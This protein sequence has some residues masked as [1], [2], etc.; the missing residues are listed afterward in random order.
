MGR[1]Y[2]SLGEVSEIQIL[3][4]HV[5]KT[6]NNFLLFQE[7]LS[8]QASHKPIWFTSVATYPD[9]LTHSLTL[10]SFQFPRPSPLSAPSLPAARTDVLFCPSSF[11]SFRLNSYF[12]RKDQAPA[13]VTL[14]PGPRVFSFTALQWLCGGYM[15]WW[16]V[17]IYKVLFAHS[18]FASA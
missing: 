1:P 15:V 6:C 8:F 2:S 13:S 14:S 7:Y 18:L 10:A 9:L 3:A 16:C 17:A 5:L 4:C 11:P 12:L